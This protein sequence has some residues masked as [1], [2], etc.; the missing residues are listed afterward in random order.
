MIGLKEIIEQQERML[1][2]LLA[3]AQLLESTGKLGEARALREKIEAMQTKL[4]S[5]KSRQ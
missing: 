3:Q 5:L 1:A 2:D 4:S